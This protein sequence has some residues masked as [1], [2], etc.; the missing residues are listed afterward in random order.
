MHLGAA[1]LDPVRARSGGRDDLTITGSHDTPT[2]CFT[3]AST[4]ASRAH[5][6]STHR[7]DSALVDSAHPSYVSSSVTSSWNA[8]SPA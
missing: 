6:A 1:R 4:R 3:H 5:S 8:I 2:V 7:S